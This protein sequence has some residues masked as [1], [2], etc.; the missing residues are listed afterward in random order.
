MFCTRKMNN[1]MNH[2]HERAL[3]IVYND[4][5]FSFE[6]LLRKDCS[7]CIH[8]RNI[9]L[10]SIEMFKVMKKLSPSI[11]NEIF[12]NIVATSNRSGNIFLRENANSVYNGENS[13]RI[14]GPI[15]LNINASN[16]I[17]VNHFII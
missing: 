17:Q 12:G 14:F 5:T 15:V 11:I 4:Y 10:V 6:F 1:K 2:I 7:V 9:H 8:H 16:E 13:M 3:R